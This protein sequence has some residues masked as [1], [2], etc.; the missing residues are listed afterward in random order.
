M[1]YLA[2]GGRVLCRL[3]DNA[4]TDSDSF[5]RACV[6]RSWCMIRAPLSLVDGVNGTDQA[7]VQVSQPVLWH[8]GV[9]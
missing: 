1:R 4:D 3:D 2:A 8:E 5:G 9:H 7:L 6:T